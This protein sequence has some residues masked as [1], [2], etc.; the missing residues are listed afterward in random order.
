V[1]GRL[2]FSGETTVIEMPEDVRV[3]VDPSRSDGQT[4]EIV[5]D[6]T[7]G[8]LTADASDFST[9]DDDDRVVEYLPLAVQNSRGLQN[10]GTLLRCDRLCYERR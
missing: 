9:H 7:C 2:I 8:R 6:R 5:G 4:S 10:Y 3:R 1:D